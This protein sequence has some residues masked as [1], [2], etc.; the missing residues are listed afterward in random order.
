VPQRH[1]Q[2]SQ[3][4]ISEKRDFAMCHVGTRFVISENDFARC[5]A[6]QG[7]QRFL[8]SSDPRLRRHVASCEAAGGDWSSLE[9]DTYPLPAGKGQKLSRGAGQRPAVSGAL[10]PASTSLDSTPNNRHSAALDYDSCPSD[11]TPWNSCS[12]RYGASV[13]GGRG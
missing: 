5:E 10:R 12:R 13:E 6:N 9:W 8:E 11:G 4:G 7:G 3:R 2:Q 1:S